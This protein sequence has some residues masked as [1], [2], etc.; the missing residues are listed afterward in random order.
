MERCAALQFARSAELSLLPFDFC[1]GMAIC[2]LSDPT[3]PSPSASIWHKRL[4]LRRLS[5]WFS[6]PKAGG[7]TLPGTPRRS[8]CPLDGPSSPVRYTKPCL[9]SPQVSW[10]EMG[11]QNHPYRR[12]ADLPQIKQ[13]G[14]LYTLVSWNGKESTMPT[15]TVTQI[16]WHSCFSRHSGHFSEYTCFQQKISIKWVLKSNREKT[17]FQ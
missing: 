4:C 17:V 1:P 8:T 12:T 11:A 9:C 3:Q 10:T 6:Q 7:H 2:G 15:Y 13:P 16:T 5:C 14:V